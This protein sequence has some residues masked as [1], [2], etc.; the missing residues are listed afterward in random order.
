MVMPSELGIIDS[1]FIKRQVHL[2]FRED[3]SELNRIFDKTGCINSIRIILSGR[4]IEAES[5]LFLGT[6]AIDNVLTFNFEHKLRGNW[7]FFMDVKL[8]YP[9]RQVIEVYQKIDLSEFFT[10]G[11]WEKEK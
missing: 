7:K 10:E 9:H 8:P 6:D 1:S 2:N 3:S 5:M 11:T 4:V